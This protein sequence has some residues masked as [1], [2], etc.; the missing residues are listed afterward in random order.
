MSSFDVVMG[1]LAGLLLLLVV[2]LMARVSMYSRGSGGMTWWCRCKIM[3]CLMAARW[4]LMLLIDVVEMLEMKS[5]M[6]CSCI[7]AACRLCVE[8]N[9]WYRLN[10]AV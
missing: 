10:A 7:G 4:V 2:R 3:W 5:M 1:F 8:Q 9:R 6:L